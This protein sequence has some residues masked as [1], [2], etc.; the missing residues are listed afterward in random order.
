[1]M[2]LYVCVQVALLFDNGS[3]IVFAC[4]MSLWAVLFLEFWKRKQFRLQFRWSTLG[5]EDIDVSVRA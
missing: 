5:Y 1:M 4:F 3:T 2:C